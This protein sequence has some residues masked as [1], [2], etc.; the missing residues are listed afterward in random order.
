[1][2]LQ[3]SLHQT[4]RGFVPSASYR[5]EALSRSPALAPLIAA[6]PAGTQPQAGDPSTDL[7]VGLSP[8]KGRESSGMV[9]LDHHLSSRV[10]AFL[11]MNMDRATSDVPLGNLKD[12]Q[13]TPLKPMNGV[14]NVT[15]ILSSSALNETRLG[16]NQIL[17]RTTN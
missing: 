5:A 11:R 12:R 8:Q 15:Q 16:F 2:G 4:L 6:Y 1:E 3:Q 9:R 14:L 10:T 7:F 13:V 17:S